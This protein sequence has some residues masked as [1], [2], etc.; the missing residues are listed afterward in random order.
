MSYR[1]ALLFRWSRRDRLAVVVIAA[2]TAL[3]VGTTVVVGAAGAET[4]RIVDDPDAVGTATSYTDPGTARETASAETVVLPVAAATRPDGT[5]TRAVGVPPDASARLPLSP[6]PP[7]GTAVGPRPPDGETVTLVGR[8]GTVSAAA[9]APRGGVIP[10]W[11]YTTRE[12]TAERLGTTGALAVTPIDAQTTA[13]RN[14]PLVG[15]SLFLRASI[16]Q[17][18]DTLGAVA[19]G[20]AV[21]VAVVVYSVT[22]MTVT[23]RL[24][25]IAVLR[26]TGLPP[27][28]VLGLFVLRSLLVTGVGVVAGYAVGLVAPSAAVNLAVFAGVPTTLTLQVTPAVL[29]TLAP[30]LAGLV[31][32]GAAGGLVGALPA[33][34]GP[35]ARL[36][37]GASWRPSPGGRL[38]A[39]L[40]P[41]LFDVWTLVPAAATLTVFVAVS[42]V[43]ASLAGT[44]APLAAADNAA[45]LQSGASNPLT[46]GLDA[47]NANALRGDGL[48]ASPEILAFSV[49]DGRPFFTRGAN[50]SAFREVSDARLV[51]GR[52]PDG[53]EEALVGDDLA[54]T[55]GVAVNDTLLLGGSTRAAVTDVRVVGRFDAAGITDDQLVVGL[56]TA[57]HLTGVNPGQVNLIRLSGALDGGETDATAG[58]AVTGISVPDAVGAGER[59]TVVVAVRNDDP[60]R[61]SRRLTVAL[62]GTT[63]TR[64]VTLAPGADR[65]VEFGFTA[66]EPGSYRVELGDANLSAPLRVVENGS[67]RLSR[68]PRRGVPNASLRVRVRDARGDPVSGT[69]LAVGNATATTGADGRAT[70][71]LPGPGSYSLSASKPGFP[72][73]TH[74][75]EVRRGID[76]APVVNL[77]VDPSRPDPLARPTATATVY[78]PWTERLERRVTVRGPGTARTVD[79]AVGPGATETVEAQLGRTE[80]GRHEVTALVDG[81]R[82]ATATYRVRGDRRVASVLASTDEYDIAGSGLGSAVARV[83]GNLEVL[84]GTLVGL[85][86][87]ATTA[88]SVAAFARAVHARRRTIGV[89][90]ATGA[91]PGQ[92]LSL[93]AADSLRVGVPATLLALLA[94]YGGVQA[95]SAA[96]VLVA[97]GVSLSPPASPALFAAVGLGALSLALVGAVGAAVGV[98]RLPPARLLGGPSRGGEEDA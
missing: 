29:E 7:R 97:F 8:A 6:P 33:V 83:V 62:D 18:L 95:L 52:S 16:G 89:R 31:A 32:V 5:A 35:P 72:A 19:A 44:L 69:A 79:V 25:A 10:P 67:L 22:R 11:W 9:V 70:V 47:D 54:D 75:I 27:R 2:V 15:V 43:V 64:T 84:L 60:T 74:R 96:G 58:V 4:T 12:A 45:V 61:R 38:P 71:R 78:N 73:A 41:S 28:G 50:Y 49:V 21:L 20:A 82:A 30:A 87:L 80:P 93:V 85:T 39:A 37:A 24:D 86:A 55:L 17:V 65:R 77:A 46:S 59:V 92:I 90:R 34:R 13:D 68:L 94:G 23:D 66:S 42:L 26:A 57:R 53:P 3:L 81:E 56:R 63:A 76:R 91:T 98:L 14:V 40:E 88:S 1:T 48:A 51:A 36:T